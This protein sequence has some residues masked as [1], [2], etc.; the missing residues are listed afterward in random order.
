MS[1]DKQNKC[2]LGHNVSVDVNSVPLWFS[3]QKELAVGTV[4][5]SI[6]LQS[7]QLEIFAVI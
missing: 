1:H 5:H 4:I 2:F 3:I 6:L 7:G